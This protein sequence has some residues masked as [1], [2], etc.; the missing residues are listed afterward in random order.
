MNLNT[1]ANKKDKDDDKTKDYRIDSFH[2]DDRLPIS[3]EYFEPQCGHAGALFN[4]AMFVQRN[5]MTATKKAPGLRTEN[6]LDVLERLEGAFEEF[7]NIRLRTLTR[8]IAKARMKGDYPEKDI[9]RIQLEYKRD[10]LI[11]PGTWFLGYEKL[12]TIFKQEN[13]EH[14][15]A[16]H[17]HVAQNALREVA[18]AFTS[19]FDATAAYKADPS[20]FTGRPKLPGYMDSGSMRTLVFSRGDCTIEEMVTDEKT[21]TKEPCLVFPKTKKKWFFPTGNLYEVGEV[22]GEVRVKPVGNGFDVHVVRDVE[23]PEQMEDN[24]CYG[25]CDLGLENLV[26]ITSNVEGIRPLIVDGREIKSINQ[27]FNKE[28]ARLQSELPQ[29]KHTSHLIYSLLAKRTNQLH[30]VLG[31]AARLCAYYAFNAGLCKLVVGK[32][33][34]W[35]QQ[36]KAIARVKQS[37]MYIPYEY[38][39]SCLERR[40]RELGIGV[41]CVEESYTSQASLTDGDIMPVWDGKS[42]KAAEKAF[43]GR[44]VTRGT[45]RNSR[46][47]ILNDDVNAAGNILRKWKGDAFAG[48]SDFRWLMNPARVRLGVFAGDTARAGSLLRNVFDI[49]GKK[50]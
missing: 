10:T 38:F 22:L 19:F 18:D 32:N 28:L 24:G 15:R 17:S 3:Q 44:R 11:P 20:G 13:N 16:L 5:T 41:E 48:I 25:G 34:G 27:Y 36:F 14:Y 1:V 46:G 40:C 2:F 21:G 37:F 35:K 43:S 8:N 30:T 9:K 29:N 31:F 39:I 50:S 33:N 23:Y 47:Q 49:D 26:T 12:D 7:R 6:E 4:S 42:K 45:Y